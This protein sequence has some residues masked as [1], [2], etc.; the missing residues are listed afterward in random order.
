MTLSLCNVSLSQMIFLPYDTSNIW[1][2]LATILPCITHRYLS[3]WALC[4]AK[5]IPISWCLKVKIF[6]ILTFQLWLIICVN[7]GHGNSGGVM[8]T[9]IPT[10]AKWKK[11]THLWQ[12]TWEKGGHFG[13]HL[14]FQSLKSMPIL[15]RMTKISRKLQKLKNRQYIVQASYAKSV[16]WFLL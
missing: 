4:M 8:E 13:N 10:Q 3:G 11:N 14:T 1:R 5:R 15:T 6:M 12:V 2:T 9:A 16:A 7:N